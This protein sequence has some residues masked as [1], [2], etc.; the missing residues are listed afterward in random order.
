MEENKVPP[1]DWYGKLPP[2]GK[3]VAWGARAIY[4]DGVVELVWDRN[5]FCGEPGLFKQAKEVVDKWLL[6]QLVHEAGDKLSGSEDRDERWEAHGWEI[7]ANPNASYG[8]L[9][10]G[11]WPIG[12]EMPPPPPKGKWKPP[13]KS[14]TQ[15]RGWASG[16]RM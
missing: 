4:R 10:I 2:E 8:Y 15:G 12:D 5:Q 11:A 7:I 16:R 9:Y 1:R 14:K 13:P 6:P 3:P